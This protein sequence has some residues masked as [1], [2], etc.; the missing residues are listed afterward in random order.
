M[1]SKFTGIPAAIAA[2]CLLAAGAAAAVSTTFGDTEFSLGGYIKLDAVYSSYSDA[3]GGNAPA[4]RGRAFTIP[5]LIPVESAGSDRD[6]ATDFTARESRF[7]IGTT[8]SKN[9]HRI[10]TFIEVDFLDPAFDGALANEE[11]LVNSSNPRMRHA[12]VAWDDPN[13]NSW[14]FGQTWS[15]F[16]DLGAY[17][18]L[19]DFI[20]P[21]EG[22]TFIRQT[23]V[24]YTRGPLQ[25]AL[26]NPETTVLP[27]ANTGGGG[28]NDNENLPDL[29]G[30]LR[31][32]R[33]D[34]SLISF[35]ALLR[36]LDGDGITPG[37]DKEI[38]YGINVSGKKM[39]G[40]DDIR[41][42]ANFGD[43]IG[44]YLGLNT[45]P[46]RGDR[47]HR[48]ARHHP[49]LRWLHRLSAH[50]DAALALESQLRLLQ[51]RSRRRL[52]RQRRDQG[53]AERQSQPAAHAGREADRGWRADLLGPRAGVRCGRQSRSP[54]VL[55]AVRLLTRVTCRRAVPG[56]APGTVLCG[57][58]PAHSML[59]VSAR[60]V[61]P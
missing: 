44:R 2:T 54:A 32:T 53:G 35:S 36:Q 19:L 41:F 4:D 5:A 52:Q 1:H 47:R 49:G 6:G 23:Q 16:M 18:D 33:N 28:F 8:T 34:G 14:L 56:P 43:G 60:V 45:A 42:Q 7:N 11:R 37:G 20:G 40:R 21:S 12:F 29:V 24:R 31:F 46:R 17:P 26:E 22:M 3:P 30:K 51:R 25:I 38:G 55:G 61:G 13:G 27:N 9:G 57:G 10:K 59:P 48:R 39:L 50:L 15:T 58:E